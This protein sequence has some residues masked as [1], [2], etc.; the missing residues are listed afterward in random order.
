[1]SN[2]R[3]SRGLC[4]VVG[5]VV[6]GMGGHDALNRLFQSSGAPGSPP[7]LAHHSKWKEW[8]FQAGMDPNTDGLVVLGNVIEEF[9]DAAPSNPFA[10]EEW[11][12]KRATIIEALSEDGLQ[13]Y[14]GGRVIPNGAAVPGSSLAPAADANMGFK[15]SSIDE[16]LGIAVRGLPRAMLPLSTRRKGVTALSFRSEYDVQ[17]LLHALL[18]PWV[19]DIRAEEFAPS[20]A[21]SNTRM[22]FLL[23]AHGI[24]VETKMVRDAAHAK[25]VGQELIIDIAHYGA[26]PKCET[27]W[28]VVYDPDR[29]IPNVG[30]L[31]S[32]LEGVHENVHGK[33]KV[34]V[35]VV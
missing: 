25:K 26:H 15:P 23:P 5:D 6:S 1:M 10:R 27:L 9:M 19:S 33:V 7:D 2:F 35:V 32:D 3:L 16:L 21:G 34:K 30:G 12:L 17:D 28:C 11:E 4:R 31:M 13:Y 18:R 22:D 14:R 20:Y 29:L 24:V 8:L